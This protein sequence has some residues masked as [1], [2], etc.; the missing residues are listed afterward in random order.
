MDDPLILDPLGDPYPDVAGAGFGAGPRL[1]DRKL[2]SVQSSSFAKQRSH[3]CGH[4]RSFGKHF[5]NFMLA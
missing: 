5:R 2:G 3:F 1:R 4:T